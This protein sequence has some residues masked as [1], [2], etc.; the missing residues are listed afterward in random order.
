LP[1]QAAADD[2]DDLMWKLL[3][4]YETDMRLLE[5][6]DPIVALAATDLYEEDGQVIAALES[7]WAVHEFTGK[8]EIRAKRQMPPNLNVAL[9][10]NIQ[11][12]PGLNPAQQAAMQQLLQ[13]AQQ[14]ILQ[15]AQQAVQDTLRANAPLQ[16][17]E[18]GFRDG[19]WRRSP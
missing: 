5:P 7:T 13:A 10:L 18:A 6:I 4:E 3:N 1:V 19:I 16:G 12:P 9:N 17:A 14:Q 15:Q 2:L 11:L 8:I